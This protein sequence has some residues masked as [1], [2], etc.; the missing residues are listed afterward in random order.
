LNSVN[1]GTKLCVDTSK[2]LNNIDGVGHA[3][4]EV[5]LNVEDESVVHDEVVDVAEASVRN[6]IC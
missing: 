1:G 4:I 5:A 3:F 2:E 6:L